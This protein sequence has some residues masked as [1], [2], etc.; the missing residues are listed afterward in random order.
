MIKKY[1]IF[2]WDEKEKKCFISIKGETFEA[3]S[4]MNPKF[5]K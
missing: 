5:D 3:P 1:V 4:L 2:K